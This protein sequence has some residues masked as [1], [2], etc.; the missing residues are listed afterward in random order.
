MLNN[1]LLNQLQD[2]YFSVSS[3]ASNFQGN[4]TIFPMMAHFFTPQNG[5]VMGLLN[6]YEDP[7]RTQGA[8]LLP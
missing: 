3:D 5:L 1:T 7:I 4:R 2:G 8:C 6:V